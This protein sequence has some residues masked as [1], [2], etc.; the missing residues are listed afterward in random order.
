MVPERYVSR[1]AT[2]A[3]GGTANEDDEGRKEEGL[4]LLENVWETNAGP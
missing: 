1:P 3:R 2:A 4:E